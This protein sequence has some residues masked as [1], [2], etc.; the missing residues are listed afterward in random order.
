MGGKTSRRGL[1]VP[2]YGATIQ[3]VR[4]TSLSSPHG[5]LAEKS[6]VHVSFLGPNP[7]QAGSSTIDA[8][9]KKGIYLFVCLFVRERENRCV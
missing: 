7:R 3:S 8:I 2:R 6:S 1:H 9:A 5:S 4:R